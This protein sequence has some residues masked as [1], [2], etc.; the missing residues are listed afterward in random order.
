M[1]TVMFL[2]MD[3]SFCMGWQGQGGQETMVD[4]CREKPGSQE[5]QTG[6]PPAGWGDES[7]PDTA[8][9]SQQ[10]P[11]AEWIIHYKQYMQMSALSRG[12]A[13]K[14]W[15]GSFQEHPFVKTTLK[16]ISGA[17]E[18]CCVS[19]WGFSHWA[20]VLLAPHPLRTEI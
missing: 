13:H 12:A 6:F 20:Q 14:W 2:D 9:Q 11:R 15:T 18:G 7:Q 5:S 8:L 4:F 1:L 10:V 19:S 17:L 16:I 3:G